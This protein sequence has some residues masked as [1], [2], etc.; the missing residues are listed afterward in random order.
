MYLILIDLQE[1]VRFSI[2]VCHLLPN[3]VALAKGYQKL[4]FV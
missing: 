2:R 4:T 1:L 3:L